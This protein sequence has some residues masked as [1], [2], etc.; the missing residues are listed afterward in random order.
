V[1]EE[2]VRGNVERHTQKHVRAALV[3]L[4]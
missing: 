4:A 3:Q 1:D 2:G